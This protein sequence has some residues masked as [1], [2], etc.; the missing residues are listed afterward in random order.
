MHKKNTVNLKHDYWPD[1]IGFWCPQKFIIGYG[2]DYNEYFR[3]LEHISV[4]SQHA[5]EKYKEWNLYR[6]FI[7]EINESL[8]ALH[9]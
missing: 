1:Y 7:K 8:L 3:D 5:L 9:L 6:F 2:M 4:I